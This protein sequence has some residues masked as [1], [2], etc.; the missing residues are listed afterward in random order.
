MV[1]CYR[2]AGGGGSNLPVIDH[3]ME[4]G[5]NEHH[6]QENS[7]SGPD[8]ISD[9]V[10]RYS[11]FIIDAG[12]SIFAGPGQGYQQRMIRVDLRKTGQT[13]VDWHL[14]YDSDSR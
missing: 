10:R 12:R 8:G 7:E 5:A 14:D 11:S 4:Q 3:N 13:T 2:L 1:P 6:Q 9:A